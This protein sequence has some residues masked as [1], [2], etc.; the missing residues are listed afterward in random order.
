[1]G[2]VMCPEAIAGWGMNAVAAK[3]AA[4][5]REVSTLRA[6]VGLIEQKRCSPVLVSLCK[7]SKLL[8]VAASAWSR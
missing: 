3:L 6:R 4:Q 5:A 1:M 2:K 7:R 8:V